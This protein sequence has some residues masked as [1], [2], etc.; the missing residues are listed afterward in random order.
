MLNEVIQKPLRKNGG[1][2]SVLH[3]A[4]LAGVSK[5]T[6]ARVF[7]E[8]HKVRAGTRQKVLEAAEQLNYTP[9]FLARGLRGGST[10]TIGIIW[11]QRGEPTVGR[12][13]DEIGKRLSK[14]GYMVP[15]ADKISAAIESEALTEYAA[16]CFDGIILQV[17]PFQE[18]SPDVISLLRQFKAVLL[19]S[20]TPLNTNFD[21]L[22]VD[23]LNAYRTVARHFVSSGRK[24]IALATNNVDSNKDKIDAFQEE[25]LNHEVLFRNDSVISSE[26]EDLAAY[27]EVLDRRFGD[28]FPFDAVMCSTDNLAVVLMGWLA[29]KGCK[30]PA[31]VAVVGFDNGEIGPYLNPALASVDRCNSASADAIAAMITNR[32]S[33]SVMSPQKSFIEMKFVWRES[34][35]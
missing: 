13:M 5:T 15:V 23:R 18:I 2:V 3:V 7:S 17:W 33:N 20:P 30:I 1:S 10:N 22:I 11:G 29:R 19:V 12:L 31:D 34:A 26:V 14:H 9:N 21:Q 24:K 28:G 16:R 4:K 6:A 32:L 35:G 27:Y 25:L 8:A